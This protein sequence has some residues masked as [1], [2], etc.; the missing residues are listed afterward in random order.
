MVAGAGA[1]AGADCGAGVGCVAERLSVAVAVALCCAWLL[2]CA[3]SWAVT[4]DDAGWAATG[5]ETSAATT[6]QARS[7]RP[8]ERRERAMTSVL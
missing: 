8:R 3:L 5:V 4:L 1:G 2:C 6:A 7:G